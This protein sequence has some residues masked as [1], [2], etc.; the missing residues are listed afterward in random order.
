MRPT[1]V[2]TAIPASSAMVASLRG[3]YFHDAW[4]IAP[5]D[6]RALPAA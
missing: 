5:D 3:A 2:E 6:A 4:A 1:P